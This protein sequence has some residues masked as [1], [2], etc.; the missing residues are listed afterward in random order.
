MILNVIVVLAV[1]I[2]CGFAGLEKKMERI[3]CLDH[4][5]KT[6]V[7]I[8]FSKCKP[9]DI[10]ETIDEVIKII[11]HQSPGTILTLINAT[12][13]LTDEKTDYKIRKLVA[14]SRLFARA[15]AVIGARGIAKVIFDTII[16]AK[17]SNMKI[18]DT[19]SEAKDWLAE[20]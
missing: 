8:D 11:S 13:M 19:L 12:D 3:S 17:R 18:F 14:H 15:E 5:G 7:Y 10:Q 1:M 20:Q 2:P 16:M 6:I 4:K 9:K